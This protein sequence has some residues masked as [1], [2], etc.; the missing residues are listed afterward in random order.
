MVELSR[1]APQF[2]HSEALEQCCGE[3]WSWAS[4]PQKEWEVRKEPQMGLRDKEPDY[5]TQG[6]LS[7]RALEL[8]IWKL[9]RPSLIFLKST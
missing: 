5:R 9:F 3:H 2:L 4:C 8:P 1:E 7:S 6:L